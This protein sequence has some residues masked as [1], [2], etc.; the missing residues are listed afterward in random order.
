MTRKSLILAATFLTA[1]LSI[2][3]STTAS[4]QTPTTTPEAENFEG[5]L[6]YR[7]YEYHS[8]L[9]RKYSSGQA[10][11]GE[12]SVEVIVKGDNLHI[13][14][15]ST[16]NHTII[17]LDKHTCYLYN[18]VS[19]QGISGSLDFIDKYLRVFAPNTPKL[20]EEVK[21]SST[22]AAVDKTEWKG[23]ECIISKGIITSGE[24]VKTDVEMWSIANCP[25]GT[26]Y[27]YFLS[28]ITTPGIV[29]KGIYSISG[30][31]KEMKSTVA[32]ELVAYR[33]YSVPESDMMPPSNIAIRT[34]TTNKDMTS[35]YKAA[36]KALKD[37]NMQP[38]PKNK[39]EAKLDIR[40]RWDFADEWM[41]S[42]YGESSTGDIWQAIG[43]VATS[44]SNTLI[45]S[46]NESEAAA[47][48]EVSI[49]SEEDNA[50]A[51]KS[52][53]S[54]S[55]K[56]VSRSQRTKKSTAQSNTKNTPANTKEDNSKVCPVCNGNGKCWECR[57]T[58]ICS[59]CDGTGYTRFGKRVKCPNCQYPGNGKCKNCDATG[60]CSNCHGS[61]K[62]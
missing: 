6:L 51:K 1:I 47:D 38:E 48:V 41:A 2:V 22:V 9:I 57:G 3:P 42:R 12:R 18:D 33:R 25:A 7:S 46:G 23:E 5:A 39:E 37:N 15:L 45:Q 61:G 29:A 53:S 50:T 55:R 59:S 20:S 28:G 19:K 14:D 56:P 49:D 16:H 11:N 43:D 36:N 4:A 34:A 60:V 21:V 17:R 10:W 52:S 54:K 62:I 32:T 30:L 58:K 8:W 35:F 40:Q 13:N 44:I 26:A 27:S 31:N 24:Q